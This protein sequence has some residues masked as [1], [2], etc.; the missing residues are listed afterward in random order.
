M[1]GKSLLIGWAQ[2]ETTPD[3]KNGKTVNILGQFHMRPAEG[4]ADPLTAT[5]LAI[6]SGAES[7]IIISSDIGLIPQEMSTGLAAAIKALNPEIPTEKILL[8]ATHIHTGPDVAVD[9]WSMNVPEIKTQAE[10]VAEWITRVAPIVVAAWHARQ[11]GALAWGYGYA[12]LGHNRRVVYFDDLSRRAGYVDAS[13]T[14]TVRNAVMYGTINDSQFSHFEGY[15]DHTVQTLFTFDAHHH[16]TGMLINAPVTAQETETLMVL[17]ADFWHETRIE[18]RKKF[19]AHVF[20]LPQ[21][22]AAGDLSPHVLLNRKAEDRMNALKGVSTRQ[23]IA[24]RIV[25]AVAE[26]FNAAKKDIRDEAVVRHLNAI[27]SIQRRMITEP[28]YFKAKNDIEELQRIPASQAATP[29][30]RLQEDSVLFAR[31]SRCQSVVDNWKQQQKESRLAV[32]CSLIRIGDVAFASNRFEPFCEFGH[33]IQARSPALQTFVVQLAGGV[34]P[35]GSYIPCQRALTGE[36]YS[37]NVYCNR[38]GPE[39]GQEMVEATLKAL[40]QFWNE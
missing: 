9:A 4:V 24:N 30:Q 19:G 25:A 14:C 29:Q 15:D 37:A 28:E 35:L 23:E 8:S 40:A 33:R 31:M 7:T 38:I 20:V 21:V 27:F 2:G 11:P 5:V 22:A 1:S 18:L 12:V 39:G 6:T 16:L 3:L 17:S 13:G 34:G 10:N 26:I 36:G 32:G